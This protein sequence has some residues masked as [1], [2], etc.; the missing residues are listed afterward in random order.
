M[1]YTGSL[2]TATLASPALAQLTGTYSKISAAP[3]IW[4]SPYVYSY[5]SAAGTYTT[6]DGGAYRGFLSG[7]EASNSAEAFFLGLYLSPTG[8]IGFMQGSF[9]PS[10][11]VN[12][13]LNMSGDLYLVQ[14]GTGSSISPSNFHSSVSSSSFSGVLS[15]SGSFGGSGSISVAQR[16]YLSLNISGQSDWGISQT[17]LQ[18]SYTGTTGNTWSLV[19]PGSYL[20]GPIDEIDITGS[21]WS[22]SKVTGSL[23]RFWANPWLTT[24]STGIEIGELYGTFNAEALTWQ[25]I[26]NSA[27]FE[28]SKFLAMACPGGTCNTTGTG[29]AS[30]QT[31]LQQLGV[32]VIEVGRTNLSGSLVA[33]TSA[34]DYV[35]V[36]MNNVIFFSPTN[37]SKPSIWATNG[38]T[39][40]YSLANGLL[41]TSNITNSN[42]AFTLSNSGGITANFQFNQWN[43]SNSSWVGSITSG[44]GSLSGGS[45]T[46]AISFKGN[47]AGSFTGTSSGTLS[48]TGAGVSQ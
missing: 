43:T 22:G 8:N 29:L 45:Y 24:P 15:S 18:G 21:I 17:K 20:A 12:S 38:V 31:A 10:S 4:Y 26:A 16:D 30:S 2:W 47:A 19:N 44:S 39:G 6:S 14:A 28:T 42:N 32:P 9:G 35:S 5:N 36:L 34:Y 41:T 25:A 48:G 13:D 37:G 7:R 3:H 23:A 11:V 27:W 46:G 40:Q 1:Q 33:G